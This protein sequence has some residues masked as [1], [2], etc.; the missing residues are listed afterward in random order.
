MISKSYHLYSEPEF[1]ALIQ[2]SEPSVARPVRLMRREPPCP[3][4]C[5]CVWGGGV[6]DRDS[7]LW[8]QPDKC[9]QRV[10]YKSSF[11]AIRERQRQE[12]QPERQARSKDVILWAV[13]SHG[14][15][16]SRS[17]VR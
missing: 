4:L 12:R 5:V 16:L 2:M 6:G 11:S 10:M 13:G 7:G 1:S 8:D 3:A 14:W 9:V 17:T 15:F